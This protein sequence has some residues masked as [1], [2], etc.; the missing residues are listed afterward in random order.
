MDWSKAQT[1]HTYIFEQPCLCT[2][3][4]LLARDQDTRNTVLIVKTLGNVC[5]GWQHSPM[6]A[7]A[8]PTASSSSTFIGRDS[9][10]AWVILRNSRSA[11][12]K[13][14][15]LSQSQNSTSIRLQDY[16]DHWMTASGPKFGINCKP[17]HDDCNTIH[18]QHINLTSS[19]PK[20]HIEW[21]PMLCEARLLFQ[22][23]SGCHP[24]IALACWMVLSCQAVRFTTQWAPLPSCVWVGLWKSWSKSL[25]IKLGAF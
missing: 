3:H 13:R 17:M 23:L 22:G 2:T 11:D 12:Q 20:T 25:W 18:L 24:R 1:V 21:Q 8:V 7:M 9:K 15:E 19:V 16:F 5:Y 6:I 14:L 4:R 10:S